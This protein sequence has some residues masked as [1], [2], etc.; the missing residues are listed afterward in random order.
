MP[1]ENFSTTSVNY[2]AKRY[3][4][5]TFMF[6]ADT[7]PQGRLKS[8][9]PVPTSLKY[10]ATR[11]EETTS[12]ATRRRPS[13]YVSQAMQA[14]GLCSYVLRYE[15]AGRHCRALRRICR[16]LQHHVCLYS[17]FPI[18]L[19]RNSCIKCGERKRCRR[20]SL[21]ANQALDTM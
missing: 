2:T 18:T 15:K 14:C 16:N 6:V 19:R 1:K 10:N 12:P 8:K 3:P 17:T 13:C 20:T 5:T 11:K 4:Y 7:T 21:R 9:R